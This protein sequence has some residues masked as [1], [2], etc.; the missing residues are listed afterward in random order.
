MNKQK[1]EKAAQVFF[2]VNAL[3]AVVSVLAIAIFILIKGMTPFI[4]GEYSLGAFLS[5]MEWRPKQAVYGVFYMLAGSVLST[6]G[7]LVLAIPL[8]TFTAIY[9]AEFARPRISNFLLAAVELLSGIPSVIFG[10]VGLGLIVPRLM[11]VSPRAEGK[12]LLA[13]ILVL[14]VMVLPII[15][16]L[17]VTALRGVP[18]SYKEGSYALGASP[19]YTVF[20]VVLPAAKSGLAAAY[21]LGIGRALGETMAVML[22]AGNPAGGLPM[23]LWDKV[24]PLTTNI[25]LEMSYSV[26]THQ[27]MLFATGVVLLAFIIVINLILNRVRK[28]GEHDQ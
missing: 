5:G 27:Q 23:S 13:V 1:L 22:V 20:K 14:T 18:E 21:I 17:A 8:G 15:V 3:L 11:A 12:S 26:G 10:I 4:S 24:R 6:A 28:L 7:A 9:I 25:A 2:L 19:T 16:S